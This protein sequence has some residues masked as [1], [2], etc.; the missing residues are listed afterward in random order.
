MH[1]I[2]G[3]R[4]VILFGFLFEQKYRPANIETV[5]FLCHLRHDIFVLCEKSW[6]QLSNF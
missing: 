6:F 2:A 5:V 3:V 4:Y 1:V